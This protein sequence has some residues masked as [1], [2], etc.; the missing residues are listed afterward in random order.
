MRRCATIL[1]ALVLRAAG[2]AADD[3][4]KAYDLLFDCRTD[5]EA[6]LRGLAPLQNP[7]GDCKRRC[8]RDARCDAVVVR[9]GSACEAWGRGGRGGAARRRRG[10]LRRVRRGP[11]RARTRRSRA[12][13]A[14]RVVASFP[15]GF[16]FRFFS[17]LDVA[18]AVRLFAR[19][20]VFPNASPRERLVAWPPGSAALEAVDAGAAAEIALPAGGSMH[21][22]LANAAPAHNRAPAPRRR[23]ACGGRS[24]TPGDGVLHFAAADAAAPAFPDVGTVVVNGTHPGCMELRRSARCEWDGK[25][26]AA[27]VGDAVALYGRLNSRTA[28]RWAQVAF[29]PSPAGPFG[30]FEPLRLLGW[31]PCRVRAASVYFVAVSPNPVDGGATALGL[32]PIFERGDCDLGAAATRDGV[33]FGP[34]AHLL[35]LGCEDAGRVRDYPADGLAARGDVVYFYVHRDMPTDHARA[36][37]PRAARLV[38]HALAMKWLEAFTAAQVAALDAAAAPA[39]RPPAAPA[40]GVHDDRLPPC[41]KGDPYRHNYLA[42]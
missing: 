12:I 41:E 7:A 22:P 29:A 28:K 35:D 32:F 16:A 37:L 39:R 9:N 3:E 1:L 38:R 30:A 18:G 4:R 33:T 17:A 15:S 19:D 10:R 26:S 27:R 14:S 36:A 31:S 20:G 11:A 25:L 6:P 5:D 21:G 2:D 24:R 34:P 8:A 42:G 23:P 13:V 40:A